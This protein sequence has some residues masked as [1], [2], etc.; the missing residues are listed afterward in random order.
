MDLYADLPPVGGVH[1]VTTTAA[2]SASTAAAATEKASVP[3]ISIA[4][5]PASLQKKRA[6]AR[7]RA[8]PTFVAA[9]SRAPPTFVAATA[10]SAAPPPKLTPPNAGGG[11]AREVLRHE[12]DPM[13]PNDYGAY[14]EA[15]AAER[16]RLRLEH[17][18][19]ED[20]AKRRRE[21]DAKR[22]RGL[23]GALDDARRGFAGE[24]GGAQR[25][26]GRGR[27]ATMPAWMRKKL[28]AESAAAAPLVGRAVPLAEGDLEGGSA[29]GGGV[30][31]GAAYAAAAAAAA[32]ALGKITSGRGVP[33]AAAGDLEG[34]RAGVVV[35]GGSSGSNS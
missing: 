14:L 35:F 12:Y 8:P 10:A 9:G 15:K 30:F 22:A 18:L 19:E 13:H 11:F 28:A 31:G 20:G 6:P 29:G 25:S 24:G 5:R 32:A 3:A 2:A 17:Q 23:E 7:R 1:A 27:G 33:P 26:G 34:G 4:F 21:A 16:K